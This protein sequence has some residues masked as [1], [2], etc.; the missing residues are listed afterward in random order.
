VSAAKTQ[1]EANIRNRHFSPEDPGTEN[2]EPGDKHETIPDRVQ[3]QA[4]HPDAAA[5]EAFARW[6]LQHE[7]VN[8]KQAVL[9]HEL[10]NLMRRIE[11]V[12]VEARR[13]ND[14]NLPGRQGTQ[15]ARRSWLSS[16]LGR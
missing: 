9:A 14:A 13:V 11:E 16:A 1:R 12:D 10:E 3:L 6:L 8:A 2:P 15:S 5:P 7:T 4:G